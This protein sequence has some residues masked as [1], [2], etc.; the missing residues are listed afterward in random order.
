MHSN[1]RK[2]GTFWAGKYFKVSHAVENIICMKVKLLPSV[3]CSQHFRDS[4][5]I[6]SSNESDMAQII[7]TPITSPKSAALYSFV[8]CLALKL[9]IEGI[10]WRIMMKSVHLTQRNMRSA[11]NEMFMYSDESEIQE[12]ANENANVWTWKRRLSRLMKIKWHLF[13][14][15]DH[16]KLARNES[17]EKSHRNNIS[18]SRDGDALKIALKPRSRQSL[19]CKLISGR[20]DVTLNEFAILAQ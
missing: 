6:I 7:C 10:K 16:R 20:N 15:K 14:A 18:N 8:M 5:L 19:Q 12:H 17:S 2:N 3:P 11:I 4:D 9:S 1:W 13:Y